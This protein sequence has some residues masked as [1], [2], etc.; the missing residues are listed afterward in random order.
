LGF[1]DRFEDMAGMGNPKK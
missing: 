1:M